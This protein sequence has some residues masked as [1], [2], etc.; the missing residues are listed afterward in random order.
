MPI[1]GTAGHVDH[2]KSTLVHALTGI[3]PDRLAEEKRRGMTIDL[4]FAHLDLPSGRRVGVVDVPGHARFLHNMLAGVHGMDVVLLVVAADEGV[5]PQTREHLDILE[6]LAVERV[7][8]ALTKVDLVDAEMVELAAADVLLELAGR[9][10]QAQVVPVSAP[11]GQGLETLL[12]A[13]QVAL[14]SGHGTPGQSGLRP[15]LPIDRVF[16]R[17]GLGVVVTGSLVD[18]NLRVGDEVEVLPP[19]G[20]GGKPALGGRPL[21]ARVRG[22]QQHGTAVA[23]GTAGNRV[24]VNLQGVDQDQVRR[25]QV[26]APVG[27]LA[28]TTCI[29]LGLALLPG[30]PALAHNARLRVFSGTSESAARVVLLEDGELEAGNRGWAQLRLVTAMALR[31]GDRVVLRRP[32]PARTIG[33]GVVVDAHA[34]PHRRAEAGVAE[35]LKR[36]GQASGRLV[37]EL[38]KEPAGIEPAALGARLGL[39]TS[40]LEVEILAAEAG[41]RAV[42]V[43]SRL[44]GARRWQTLEDRARST[45]DE[46]HQRAPLRAG[47]PREALRG[48]LELSGRALAEALEAMTM[49]GVIEAQGTQL[50]SLPGWEPRLTAAQRAVVERAVGLLAAH[51]LAPPSM[52][53]LADVGLDAD[54]TDYAEEQG[55]LLRIGQDVLLVPA[56]VELA[57]TTLRPHLE[58]QGSLS[59]AQARDLLGSSRRVVVPL[60]EHLDA[61]HFTYRDGDSRRLR[62]DRQAAG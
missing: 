46:Y 44:H 27:A 56:A 9:G 41:G 12:A 34:R 11:L 21:R 48:R 14:D 13:L 28:P 49:R 7:V 25:G 39:E 8:V 45:L 33:G 37:E 30:V 50:V 32:S 22:L 55:L 15:R 6:L 59:V 62:R 29:D 31:D 19:L 43:G 23:V 17:P 2:G 26:L 20:A 60:L 3:D 58:A 51:P 4:G 42:R 61:T 53:D 40:D 18:G 47:M 24:A 38:E 1:I 35:A 16:G 10:I 54:L 36:R 5:M 57:V 52:A